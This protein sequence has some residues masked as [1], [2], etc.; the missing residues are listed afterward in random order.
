MPTLVLLRHGQSQWNLENRFTGWWDVDVTEK[1]E[2]EARAAG[3]LLVDKGMDLDRVFTSVQKRAIRTA[4]LALEAMDRIWLPMTKDWRLNE[5]H[6]GG[7]TGLNKAETV[8]KVG[9]EQVKIWR[10]SF[11]VPPP[12][13]EAD[14]PYAALQDD[15]RYAGITVPESESLKDTIARV[16][17]YYEA[18]I[19]PALKRGERVLVAAHGNSLRALEKHLS[20]I[21]DADITGL[22]IPT[23]QPIVYEL[24]DNLQKRDR[25]YLSQR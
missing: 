11:D 6:Y 16:L 13:L 12:P 24:D 18:E 22:E 8:A 14:S 4:N 20:G 2:A 9:E 21:S 3:Q 15:R 23:G 5:R 17:P 25:Y 19:A 10:R 1:G 7:L